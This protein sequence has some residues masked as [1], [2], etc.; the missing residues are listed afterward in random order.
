MEAHFYTGECNL[1]PTP[2]RWRC[3]TQVAIMLCSIRRPVAKYA[4][5]QALQACMSCIYYL[6][7]GHYFFP[8]PH[9][10]NFRDGGTF[11]TLENATWGRHPPIG[12]V[13]PK[14]QYT[15]AYVFYMYTHLHTFIH[16]FIYKQK[17]KSLRV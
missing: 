11:F 5:I 10:H 12:G 6:L 15:C 17:L 9:C 1:G 16:L 8:K 14:L 4:Y 3:R 13:G 7:H 2:S